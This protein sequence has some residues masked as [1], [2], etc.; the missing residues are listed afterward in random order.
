MNTVCARHPYRIFVSYSSDDRPIV[1][2]LVDKLHEMG[3]R[4]VWDKDIVPSLHF[5]DEIKHGI[6]HA[7]LFLPV[8]TKSSSARP[9]VHQETGYAMGLEIPVLPLG[10]GRVPGNMIH[11][12]QAMRVNETLEDLSAETLINAIHKRLDKARKGSDTT[13]RCASQPED[14]AE[15]LALYTREAIGEGAQGPLRQAGAMTSFNLPLD[16]PKVRIWRDRD[17]PNVRSD[18]IH[19]LLHEERLALDEYVR[20]HGAKLIIDPSLP[21]KSYSAAARRIR[22]SKLLEFLRDRSVQNVHVAVRHRTT[23]GNLTIVG[24]WF[25][26]ESVVPSPGAGITRPSSPGMHPACWIKSARSTLSS[27]TFCAKMGSRERATPRDRRPSKLSKPNSRR[28]SLLRARMKRDSEPI[29][30]RHAGSRWH[31]AV[32]HDEHLPAGLDHALGDVV[33]DIVELASRQVAKLNAAAGVDLSADVLVGI[34]EQRA[35]PRLR[36]GLGNLRDV[37]RP[38]LVGAGPAKLIEDIVHLLTVIG[39]DDLPRLFVQPVDRQ[40]LG[41]ARDALV[42]EKWVLAEAGKSLEVLVDRAE[43]QRQARRPGV[44]FPDG[45][46]HRS[47]IA[48]ERNLFFN[49]RLAPGPAGNRRCGLAISVA[50]TS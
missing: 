4:P 22:L 30:R 46:V 16:P 37:A 32:G 38:L 48:V 14:R 19:Q 9:W 15:M 8:L 45:M 27:T 23:S 17:E 41:I 39:R 44:V 13:Y 35:D 49:G 12:L 11:D 42:H 28:R 6:A 1:A 25:G 47:K 24:D 20:Q 31:L 10:I 21:L 40:R 26:A 2:K 3:L 5:P 43:D 29:D 18:K 36:G 7:H 34:D 50:G 33:E